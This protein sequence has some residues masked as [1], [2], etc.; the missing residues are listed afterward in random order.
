MFVLFHPCYGHL[1][2]AD[3]ETLRLMKAE[4]VETRICLSSWKRQ[5]LHN[6][7]N[8]LIPLENLQVY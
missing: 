4:F 2:T 3:G 7:Q 8:P 6:C 5:K 1:Y